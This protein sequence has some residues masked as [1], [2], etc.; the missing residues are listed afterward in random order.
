MFNLRLMGF[1]AD[2]K[3][4]D[5]IYRSSNRVYDALPL[6]SD[7][8]VTL[9]QTPEKDFYRCTVSFNSLWGHSEARESWINPKQALRAALLSITEDIRTL[10]SIRV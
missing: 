2:P 8:N 5:D 4:L 10:R 6:D 3:L 9:A 1:E 7:L